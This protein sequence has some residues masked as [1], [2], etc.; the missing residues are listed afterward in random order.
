MI[1]NIP[2]PIQMHV[3]IEKDAAFVKG[4]PANFGARMAIIVAIV[5]LTNMGMTVG[6]AYIM[7]GCFRIWFP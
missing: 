1:P 6:H 5:L 4:A 3:M 7:V 2:V